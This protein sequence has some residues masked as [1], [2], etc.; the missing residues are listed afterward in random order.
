MTSLS[1]LWLP[2]LVSGFAVFFLSALMWMAMPHHKKDYA[3]LPDEDGFMKYLRGFG[4]RGQYSFPHCGSHSGTKDPAWQEKTKLGPC[5]MLFILPSQCNM[6]KALTLSL[7]HNLAVATFVAYL[8]AHSLLPGSDFKAVFRITGAATVLAYCA[9]RFADGIWMGHSW[10]SV[11]GHVFDGL[12]YAVATG[13]VFGWLW[14]VSEGRAM[15]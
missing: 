3:K 7:I 5:G 4:L 1:A 12:V 14:P 10:R 13:A 9:A 11:I 15:L 8:A 2:I 6:G